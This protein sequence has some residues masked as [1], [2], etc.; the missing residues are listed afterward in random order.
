MQIV[1]N[2]LLR[3]TQ[4]IV[5]TTLAAY[6]IKLAMLVVVIRSEFIGLSETKVL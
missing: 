4:G 2:V 6:I 5:T 1:S 3:Q